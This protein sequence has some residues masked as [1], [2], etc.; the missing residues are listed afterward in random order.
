MIG[1]ALSGLKT[2]GC[3]LILSLVSASVMADDV[4]QVSPVL[5]LIPDQVVTS[6]LF[7]PNTYGGDLQYKLK[8]EYTTEDE[9]TDPVFR[10]KI[11]DVFSNSLS[12]SLFV[13]PEQVSVGSAESNMLVRLKQATKEAVLRNFLSA[14]GLVALLDKDIRIDLHF[15][16]VMTDWDSYSAEL[17]NNNLVR[18]SETGSLYEAIR[19]PEPFNPVDG[20]AEV[21]DYIRQQPA[22]PG[23]TYKYLGGTV[24]I[25]LKVADV[26]WTFSV[27][28]NPKAN[29]V[30]GYL[31]YR[32]YYGF[33]KDTV[34]ES[35]RAI[36][37]LGKDTV[38]TV[39][40]Y[41]TFN[42]ESL[43]AGHILKDEH[44][45][46]TFGKFDW[47]DLSRKDLLEAQSSREFGAVARSQDSDWTKSYYAISRL[48]YI[49][50]EYGPGPLLEGDD[51]YVWKQP[52]TV[53]EWLGLGPAEDDE[54]LSDSD[55]YELFQ[56]GQIFS[57][58][59]EQ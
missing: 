30:K 58:G 32:R 44:V 38:V 26:Q 35:D 14:S 31:R 39:D 57:L 47:A 17:D 2:T 53:V 25:Y 23:D 13:S 29:A 40:N 27:F 18:Q 15:L 51:T 9:F 41:Q 42:L 3:L 7:L 1:S 46:V 36:G 45:A 28:P 16:P 33:P 20:F 21:L 48:N 8:V 22:V 5:N 54:A 24:S 34:F 56:L 4:R 12:Q 19:D 37:F 55:F 59:Q 6:Q 11:Q 10:K 49:W 52:G 50:T 43:T